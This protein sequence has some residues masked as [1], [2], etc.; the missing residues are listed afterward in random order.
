MKGAKPE[1][2]ETGK[3]IMGNAWQ[4]SFSMFLCHF[5]RSLC[6]YMENRNFEFLYFDT[7]IAKQTSVMDKKQ[8]VLV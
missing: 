5:S 3:Q 4:H 1:L 6:H 8:T 2:G 7:K